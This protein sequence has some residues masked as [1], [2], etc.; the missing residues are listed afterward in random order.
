MARGTGFGITLTLPGGVEANAEIQ[1][2]NNS[3][4]AREVI[5][6]THNQSGPGPDFGY[7]EKQPG[8]VIDP[9]DLEIEMSFDPAELVNW[10]AAMED[11]TVG[12]ITV[13]YLDGTT[14]SCSGFLYEFEDEAP[15][16]DRMTAT[17]TFAKSG[18]PT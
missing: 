6:F 14:R 1:A 4:W 10:Q 8:S 15:H 9:G 16:D 5:D 7:M 3:G 2:V 17:A 12:T 18:Q 13:T 11:Q